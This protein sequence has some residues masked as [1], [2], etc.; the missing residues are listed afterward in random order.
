M[1]GSG[2]RKNI[3]EFQKIFPNIRGLMSQSLQTVSFFVEDFSLN[4]M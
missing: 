1:R 4:V 3:T 2:R